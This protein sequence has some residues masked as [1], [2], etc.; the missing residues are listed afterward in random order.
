MPL[1]LL[2]HGSLVAIL[3]PQVL[4]LY[5]FKLAHTKDRLMEISLQC[6]VHFELY[7]TNVL[8]FMYFQS[9]T[10]YAMLV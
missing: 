9:W 1:H 8:C 6:Q 5:V 4:G 10:F 2:P 7:Y 3:L